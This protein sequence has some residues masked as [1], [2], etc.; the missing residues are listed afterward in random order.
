[1][2]GVGMKFLDGCGLFCFMNSLRP[3]KRL[4]NNDVALDRGN[5]ASVPPTPTIR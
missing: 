3:G 4:E 1:M 5:A 2:T